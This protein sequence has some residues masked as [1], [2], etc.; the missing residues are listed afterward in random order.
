MSRT[1][2]SWIAAGLFLLLFAL[3]AALVARGLTDPIDRAILTALR[4]VD[5]P[6]VAISPHWTVTLALWVTSLGGGRVRVPLT[7][8]AALGLAMF[9]RRRA[10]LLLFGVVASGA[11]ALPLLKLLFHRA[12]PDLPWRLAVEN[13]LSFPSG[14]AMG[15]ML[16]YPLLGLL[17]GG[18]LGGAVGVA[19]AVAVGLTRVFLGVHWASDVI[20]G[21][22]IGTAWLC[23][24]LALTGEPARASRRDREA[25]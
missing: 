15:S 8:A 25:E 17:L 11:A 5:L 21:W 2:T 4:R 10:G 19:I 24:A 1:R 9:G 13:D 7:I 12:R 20:G 16:L 14:H 18:R 6:G 23:A 3:D 22:A